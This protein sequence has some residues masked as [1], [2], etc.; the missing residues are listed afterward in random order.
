MTGADLSLVKRAAIW[1]AID[2]VTAKFAGAGLN[3]A[4][5]EIGAVVEQFIAQQRRAASAFGDL[6]L[7]RARLQHSIML[8]FG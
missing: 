1:S 2:L 8:S 4:D 7:L 5:D 3:D 6:S